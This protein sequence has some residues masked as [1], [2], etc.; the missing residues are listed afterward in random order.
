MRGGGGGWGLPPSFMAKDAR[1]KN[2]PRGIVVVVANIIIIVFLKTVS[3]GNENSWSDDGEKVDRV[4]SFGGAS[5][6][7]GRVDECSGR[8]GRQLRRYE[9]R[10]ERKGTNEPFSND[11]TRRATDVLLLCSLDTVC[12]C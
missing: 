1:R 7:D 2:A 11:P 8:A 4:V 6:G 12:N 10:S 9:R 5:D 3:L